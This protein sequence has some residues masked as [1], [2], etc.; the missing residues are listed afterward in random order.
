MNLYCIKCSK[1]TNKINNIKIKREI[2]RKV[3][4]YFHCIGFGLKKFKNIDKEEL[5]DLLKV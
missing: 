2:D 1:F 4:L 3:K 5:S